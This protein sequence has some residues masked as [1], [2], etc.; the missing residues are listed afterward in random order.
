MRSGTPRAMPAAWPR[1]AALQMHPAASDSPNW[2]FDLA[3]PVGSIER[4]GALAT[5]PSGRTTDRTC[6]VDIIREARLGSWGNFGGNPFGLRRP[7]PVCMRLAG[8]CS[9][10]A[11]HP[12][13]RHPRP[14]DATEETR[15]RAGFFLSA[16]PVGGNDV[17]RPANRRRRRHRVESA[18][19]RRVA[20]TRPPSDTGIRD[21]K[22]GDAGGLY[23]ETSPEAVGSEHEARHSGRDG[24]IAAKR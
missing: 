16:R 14:F 21:A 12:V 23:V 2:H 22:P 20:P 10:D 24:A 13:R 7:N 4:D 18:H 3:V 11:G 9:V 5:E 17:H 1:F 15:P 6:L 19:R 8:P